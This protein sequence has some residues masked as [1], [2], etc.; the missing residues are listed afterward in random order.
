LPGDREGD[1]RVD[2]YWRIWFYLLEAAG[3]DVQ[4]VNAREA[5]N[6]PGRPKTDLLTEQRGVAAAQ[7]TEWLLLRATVLTG[8]SRTA[9]HGCSDPARHA[10]QARGI[11]P[12]LDDAHGLT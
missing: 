11:D 7:R 10:G 2:D 1:D 3:L 9:G 8:M 5:R 6:M 4:L 12:P